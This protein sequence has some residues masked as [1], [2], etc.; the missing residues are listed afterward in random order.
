M[1]SYI[2]RRKF[3]ATLGGAAAWPLAAV[4]LPRRTFLHL[5]AGAAALPVVSRVATAQAYNIRRFGL[6]RMAVL[7]ENVSIHPVPESS[8]TRIEGIRL[9]AI[10]PQ[11]RNRHRIKCAIAALILTILPWISVIAIGHEYLPSSIALIN[12]LFVVALVATYFGCWSLSVVLSSSPRLML[13]RALATTLIVMTCLLILEVPAM[14]KVVDWAVVMQKLSGE[15]HN[16]TTAFVPDKDLAFRR[17]PNLHWSGRPASDIEEAYLL[18]RTLATPITFAYDRWGYRNTTEMERASIVLIGDSYVEGWYVSDEQTVASR[19]AYR[20]GQP[21]ANLGVAGYGA[22]QELRVLKGQ[23][24]ARKPK[25]IAWFFFEGND[26]Y[27]DDAF[28]WFLAGNPLPLEP[29]WQHRSFTNN[30][31]HWIRRWTHFIVP[32]RAPFWALLPGQSGSAKQI[33][34]AYY[35]DVPWTGY[36]ERRWEKAKE[37]FREGIEAARSSGAEVILVYVPIKFRVYREFIRI[38]PHSPL[39]NW[40]VWTSL[41]QKFTEFCR[42]VSVPCVDLTAR[43]QQAVREGVDVYALTDTHWSSDGHAVVAAELERVLHGLEQPVTQ[44]LKNAYDK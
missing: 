30:A 23:A 43:L 13:M 36:E 25:V 4:K 35:G 12:G 37:A 24:L 16:Y 6:S 31:F 32:N 15:D 34:F 3:L 41:P 21:V 2:G 42:S 19:L 8:G 20:L 14:L 22:M 33:Y 27:D 44:A 40:G 29:D 18:P 17:I 10:S 1:A 7:Q 9:Q 28:E 5:A 38:P 11:P 26:L 39:R